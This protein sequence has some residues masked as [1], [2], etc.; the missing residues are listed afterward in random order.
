MTQTRVLRRVV[1]GVLILLALLVA[2][3]RIGVL[4]A[5]RAAA[6]TLQTS[7][8]LSERPSVGIGGFPFLTQIAAGSLD[9]VTVRASDVVVGNRPTLRLSSVDA[10]LHG[11]SV[12]RDLSTVRADSA[13]GTGVVPYAEL[14]RLL[15]VRVNYGGAGRVVAHPAVT[16]AGQQFSTAV[17]AQVSVDGGILR[18]GSPRVADTSVPQVVVDQLQAVFGL[19]VPLTGIPFGLQ[20]HSV[21]AGSDGVAITLVGHQLSYRR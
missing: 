5:E 12:S 4:L 13:Q 10:T 8:H 19:N 3:D 1:I 9:K 11:L 18:F 14:T 15:G 6:S 7:E 21:T 2:A 17:S 20:V 16:V